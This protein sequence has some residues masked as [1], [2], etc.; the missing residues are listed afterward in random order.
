MKPGNKVRMAIGLLLLAASALVLPAQAANEPTIGKPMYGVWPLDPAVKSL[1]P[2]D[3]VLTVPHWTNSF[4]VK[5]VT[6]N[7]RMVGTSP[8]SGSATTT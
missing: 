5:D 1:A 4:K 6:Y 3:S 8:F 2:L 7:Y